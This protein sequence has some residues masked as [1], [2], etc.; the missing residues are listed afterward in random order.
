MD[1]KFLKYFKYKNM[2]VGIT[3]V[4]DHYTFFVLD[5]NVTWHSG[6]LFK[7][8]SLLETSAKEYVD[9]ILFNRT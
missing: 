2:S 7:N 9:N 4:K 5:K 6:I 1:S 8:I 3:Q